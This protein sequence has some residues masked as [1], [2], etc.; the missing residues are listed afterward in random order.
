MKKW[1]IKVVMQSNKVC[2]FPM[3][4]SETLLYK[5]AEEGMIDSTM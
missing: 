3:H 2:T 4:L 5:Q 1:K